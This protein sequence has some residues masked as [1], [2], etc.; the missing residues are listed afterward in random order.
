MVAYIRRYLDACEKGTLL[1]SANVILFFI[2]YIFLGYYTALKRTKAHE[3]PSST[4][5]LQLCIGEDN[6]DDDDVGDALK[7]N[8]VRGLGN[9]AFG[10][11]VDDPELNSWVLVE[12]GLSL[13][14]VDMTSLEICW[15]SALGNRGHLR[16]SSVAR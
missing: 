13:G 4:H 1:I 6:C 2:M 15:L 3:P 11:S 9:D 8:V 14:D 10:F 16:P 5:H 7:F 12:G